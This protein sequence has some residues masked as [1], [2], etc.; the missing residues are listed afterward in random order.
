MNF[1]DRVFYFFS[2]KTALQ[3]SAAR[4]QLALIESGARKYE[5]ASK[6][7]RVS[8]WNPGDTSANDEIR[9]GASGLRARARDLRRNNAYA[10]RAIQVLTTNVVG[11]GIKPV[12][13]IKNKTLKKFFDQAWKDWAEKTTACDFENFFNLQGLQSLVMDSVAESGEVFILRKRLAKAKGVPLKLQLLEADFL[14]NAYNADLNG[15]GRIRQGIEFNSMGDRVAYHFWKNHPG[16]TGTVRL[17]TSVEKIRVPASEVVHVFEKKRPGQIRGVS[18]LHPVMIRLHDL[19]IFQDASLKKQ[20]ISACFAGFIYNAT[21]DTL[22]NTYN[23]TTDWELLEKLDSGTIE[24]LP[25]GFDIKFAEP[26]SSQEYPAFVRTEL[27]SIAS[28]LGI[29]YEALTGDYSNVNFSSAR[30]G[31]LEFQRN[32]KRWQNELM[33]TQFLTTVFDWFVDAIQFSAGSQAYNI[34]ADKVG[35]TWTTP[36]RE[37]VDPSK[38]IPAHRDAVKAGFKSISEVI[39]SMGYNP[40]EVFEERAKEIVELKKLGIATDSDPSLEKAPAPQ[41]E[42]PK[43]EPKGEKENEDPDTQD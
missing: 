20:Q 5:G 13:N 36:A 2:P 41:P 24:T 25:P 11:T 12:F 40:D 8:L 18:F 22:P 37:M 28:G 3:R 15:G 21:G 43:T 4:A 16:E 38:E 34:S 42:K 29:T 17:G 23:Q 10:H 7:S 35:V 27:M 9:G 33:I 14:D 1:L 19:D 31:F 39:R 30:M 6:A 32:I 26:P